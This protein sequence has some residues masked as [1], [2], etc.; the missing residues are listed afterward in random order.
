MGTQLGVSV[1][2]VGVGVTGAGEDSA[3]LDGGLKALFAECE[4]FKLLE[5]IFIC[6]TAGENVRK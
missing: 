4:A 1:W 3:A 6:R 5:A 2:S